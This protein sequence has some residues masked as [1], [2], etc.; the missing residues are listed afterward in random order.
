MPIRRDDYERMTEQRIAAEEQSR[1]AERR[2]WIIT[3]LVCT[4]WCILGAVITGAG[5]AMVLRPEDAEVLIDS[6]QGIAAAGVL[7]TVTYASY[8]RRKR[9][10][11]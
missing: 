10:L 11:D 3:L 9:G 6:G 1:K 4:L 2:Y 7:V 8:H 5:F